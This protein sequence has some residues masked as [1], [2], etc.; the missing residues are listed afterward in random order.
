MPPTTPAQRAAIRYANTTASSAPARTTTNQSPGA[1]SSPNSEKT[2]VKST[3]S[4]FHEDPDIVS[5]S[6]GATSRP[7]MIHDHGSLPGGDARISDSAASTTQPSTSN[8]SVG[9]SRRR[10]TGSR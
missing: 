3:G 6:R 9:A 1:T 5:R 7:Q 4:G 10:A 2:V 8:G